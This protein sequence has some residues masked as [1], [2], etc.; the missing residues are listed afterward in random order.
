MLSII[1]VQKVRKIGV[2]NRNKGPLSVDD[3]SK[4]NKISTKRRTRFNLSSPLLK[5]M[6]KRKRAQTGSGLTNNLAS[7]GLEDGKKGNQLCLG[8]K[9]NKQRYQ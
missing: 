4:L 9:T 2:I 5:K 1:E 3:L 6:K 7:L 8:Q